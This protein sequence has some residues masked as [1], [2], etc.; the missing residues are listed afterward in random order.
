MAAKKQ[1]TTPER[2]SFSELVRGRVERLPAFARELDEVALCTRAAEGQRWAQ[3]ME[4]ALEMLR[5]S[6]D[7]VPVRA[8]RGKEPAS[9]PFEASH[10]GT[11]R[12]REI[13]LEAAWKAR[14][15]ADL[16]AR[17]II[18]LLAA[19]YGMVRHEMAHG[20][21]PSDAIAYVNARLATPDEGPG[22]ELRVARFADVVNE[23]LAF[24]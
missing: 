4:M 3:A 20:S 15:E 9:E 24:G 5:L 8:V 16:G 22:A 23:L 1:G 11:R 14:S 21:T 17:G 2:R 18:E 13:L 7:L 6:V 19:Q 10:R 12:R